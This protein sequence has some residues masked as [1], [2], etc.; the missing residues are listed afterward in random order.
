MYLSLCKRPRLSLQWFR[1]STAGKV[2]LYGQTDDMQHH[3]NT[4]PLFK[5]GR[6]KRTDFNETLPGGGGPRGEYIPV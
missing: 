5:G 3:D 6:I 4:L 1:R 2:K